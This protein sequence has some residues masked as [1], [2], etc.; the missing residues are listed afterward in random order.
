M[1]RT[2]AALTEPTS[3]TVAPGIRCGP[4]SAATSPQAPTGTQ[5]MTR[6]APA[7]AAALVS[8]HLI[9]KPELGDA[10]AR[11]GGTGGRHDLAHRALRARRACDRRAD[12]ADADQREPIV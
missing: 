4:I 9:G 12:Q 5:T 2:T 3:E 6:S 8:D 10:P 1:S 7:T 11:R